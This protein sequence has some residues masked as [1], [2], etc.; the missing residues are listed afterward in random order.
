MH[1]VSHILLAG[2]RISCPTTAGLNAKPKLYVTKKKQV[3][4]KICVLQSRGVDCGVVCTVMFLNSNLI[5]SFVFVQ[6]A[7]LK[8][9]KCNDSSTC[10][11][12]ILII[13]VALFTALLPVIL[14]SSEKT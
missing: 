3:S 8:N 11:F 10:P 12:A 14:A 4:R 6:F 5:L 9:Y 7:A 2:K 1:E 13:I